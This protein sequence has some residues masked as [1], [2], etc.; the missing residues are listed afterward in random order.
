[1][2]Y[3]TVRLIHGP[4]GD[5]FSGMKQE[6]IT[7]IPPGTCK[8][9][10]QVAHPGSYAILD[11]R[12]Y[13][14]KP[15]GLE[16]TLYFQP[17]LPEAKHVQAIVSTLDVSAKTGYSVVLT[18]HGIV[19]FW[20]GT[21]TTVDVISTGFKPVR[22]MWIEL[23][24]TIR[25]AVLRYEIFPKASFLE[26]TGSPS[27]GS[28]D[29]SHAADISK[30][31]ILVFAGSFARSPE[32]A[33][34]FPTNFFNG[35]LDSPTI[36]TACPGN[37]I[38][39]K[40]DFALNISSDKIFDV[41]EASAEGRLVNAPMR[42][43]TGHNW[44]ATESDWTKAKYGYGA[45]HF[46]EDDLDNAAWGTDF[47][48]KLPE[49]LRSGVY[50]IEIQTADGKVRD[51]VP[52]YIRPTASS[53]TTLGAKVA[54]IISTFTASIYWPQTHVYYCL[55]CAVVPCLCKR[56]RIRQDAPHVSGLRLENT[57]R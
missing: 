52:F 46:H 49:Y 33:S 47:S 5:D 10:Y 44:D 19:E 14:V 7:E 23:R 13:Q 40:W 34:T 35:R 17:H 8:G 9:R 11:E 53:S 20:I 42:A 51:A 57:E 15:T 41:S 12:D 48:I 3:H 6:L 56:T 16:F 43:V 55:L 54:Y 28:K 36:K 50:A 29:L 18:D 32:E 25:S 30:P 24:F 39:A 26:I 4:Q 1:L 2:K 38:L 45:I 21:G 22:K 31:C 37:F 27:K